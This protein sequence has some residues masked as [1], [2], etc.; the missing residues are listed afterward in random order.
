MD[1]SQYIYSSSSSSSLIVPK[2]SFSTLFLS[3]S[4]SSSM[5]LSGRFYKWCEKYILIQSFISWSL[6]LT[7]FY[8]SRSLRLSLEMLLFCF[9]SSLG[10]A[11]KYS[12]SFSEGTELHQFNRRSGL[13]FNGSDMKPY[14]TISLKSGAVIF[15]SSRFR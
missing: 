8:S 13:D 7:C 1:S 15:I 4:M 2:G 12:S 11:T 5:S 14:A 9:S 3:L 6:L 10:C